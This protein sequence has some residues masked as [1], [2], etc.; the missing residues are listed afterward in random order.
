MTPEV[1]S[2]EDILQRVRDDG[3]ASKELNGIFVDILQ[4][5]GISPGALQNNN[6]RYI[7]AG[8]DCDFIY[9]ILSH[10]TE[11]PFV[12]IR[13]HRFQDVDLSFFEQMFGVLKRSMALS[14]KSF[15]EINVALIVMDDKIEYSRL[16]LQSKLRN[17]MDEFANKSI[18]KLYCA[19]YITLDD[20]L[21]L[22]DYMIDQIL[23][24]HANQ[25]LPFVDDV[26][27][28]FRDERIDEAS[29]SALDRDP[30]GSG[31]II[32][33]DNQIFEAVKE[34][35][36]DTP[37]RFIDTSATAQLGDLSK[38]I[39]AIEAYRKKQKKIQKDFDKC[40]NINDAGR[41]IDDEKYHR[42][43][44]SILKEALNELRSGENKTE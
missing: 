28:Y 26:I 38:K 36:P 30:I 2:L 41:H 37:D 11:Q 16:V 17:F 12:N 40:H 43:S 42:S 24:S 9:R 33:A 23:I 5:L 8:E 34:A 3:N 39:H 44:Q 10:Y 4:S 20:R 14:G 32:H 6:G 31:R 19:N 22:I 21:T 29:S 13:K 18:E 27:D 7:F 1:C 35:L 15:D 25:S